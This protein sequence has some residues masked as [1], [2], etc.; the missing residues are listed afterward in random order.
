MKLGKERNAG[1]EKT[2]KKHEINKMEKIR[3]MSCIG[4]ISWLNLYLP[5]QKWTMSETLIS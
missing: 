1:F 2:K 4:K 3:N 5:R